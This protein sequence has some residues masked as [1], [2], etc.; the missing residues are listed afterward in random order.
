MQQVNESKTHIVIL[1][2]LCLISSSLL[3]W[4]ETSSLG[5]F[6]GYK[7]I[8]GIIV[9]IAMIIGI[10]VVLLAENIN[11]IK[12]GAALPSFSSFFIAGYYILNIKSYEKFLISNYG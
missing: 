1:L 11:T 10:F 7:T 8:W 12:W 3:P 9:S 5:M 6:S 4:F 2:I